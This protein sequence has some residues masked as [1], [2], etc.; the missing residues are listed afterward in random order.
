M[1]TVNRDVYINDRACACRDSSK[2]CCR[3]VL[4]STKKLDFKRLSARH[5]AVEG[6]TTWDLARFRLPRHPGFADLE[7]P[8]NLKYISLKFPTVQGELLFSAAVLSSEEI[9]SD[10][11]V[12]RANLSFHDVTDR[13][14]FQAQFNLI[15]GL[16]DL[17]L[18][19]YQSNLAEL[20]RRANSCVRPTRSKTR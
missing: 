16:R 15:V 19:E 8:T 11:I 20:E 9:Y 5:E 17:D 7:S 4:E 14:A 10:L 18:K 13:E 1:K 6:L 12:C 3:V 2:A